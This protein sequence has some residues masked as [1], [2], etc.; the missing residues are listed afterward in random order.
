MKLRKLLKVIDPV[1]DVIVFRG[2]VYERRYKPMKPK[3]AQ[4]EIDDEYLNRH[5]LHVFT[6]QDED[7]VKITLKE[8]GEK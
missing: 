5:V 6:Q 8:K 2:S 7:V 3:E 1:Q 4:C